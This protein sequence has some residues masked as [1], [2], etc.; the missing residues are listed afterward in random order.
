MTKIQEEACNLLSALATEHGRMSG[1]YTPATHNLQ[2][3]WG[4]SARCLAAQACYASN[5][6]NPYRPPNE[7]YAEAE[8]LIR[9]GSVR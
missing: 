8:A 2:G 3:G 4:S 5:A 9:D 1:L 7:F 6:A